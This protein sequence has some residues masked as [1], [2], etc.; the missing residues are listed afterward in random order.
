[1]A[2]LIPWLVLGAVGYL[3]FGRS[4]LATS[5]GVRDKALP[6]SPQPLRAGIPY[7]FIIRLDVAEA[8]AREVLEGKGVQNLLF[9]PAS[10]PPFWLTTASLPFS[11]RIASFKATPAGNSQVTLGDPFYGIGRLET[12]VRLDGQPFAAPLAIT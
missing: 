2:S 3:M 12:L 7:L 11:T 9:S 10:N 5:T 4:A 8:K 1:M 6:G